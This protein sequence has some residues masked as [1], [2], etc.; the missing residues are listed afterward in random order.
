LR[1]R[2]TLVLVAAALLALPAVARASD[3]LV[4]EPEGTSPVTVS[5]TGLGEPDVQAREYTI[6]D[7][8]GERRVPVTGYS[9]DKVLDAANVDP[10]RFADLQVAAAAGL[11]V[12]LGRDEV[13][14][15]DTFAE[16]PPV[17]WMDAEEARFLRPQSAAA[18]SVLVSGG[19]ITVS[20]S[21]LSELEV[22]VTASKRRVKVGEPVTFTATVSGAPDGQEVQLDWYFD[23]ETEGSGSRIT[24]RFMR[25]G[26]YDVL[27]GATT[28]SDRTGA[29]ATASVRVGRPSGG[30]NRKG[31]G[32]NDDANAPDSG[33]ATGTDAS[34]TGGSGGAAA[35]AAG[36]ATEEAG[37]E[38][39]AAADRRRSARRRARRE[40]RA[41]RRER[42]REPE[43]ADA[44]SSREVSGIELADL[45]ALSSPAGRDALQAART[46]RLRDE[47]EEDDGRGVPPAVWWTLGTAA[48]LGLGG[49]REARG[50]PVTRAA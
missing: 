37:A 17:F 12:T 4:V 32:T 25:R 5:L 27:V 2:A 50:R 29:S 34:G 38:G 48:L 33:S 30:P 47:R 49:W 36:D 14:R 1:A 31:G 24:H 41:E 6:D 28:A 19:A 40:R 10:Y 43:P 20:L 39:D 26:T 9:L 18:G 35:A 23:D 21:R 42:Q 16:G 13:V 45:S 22:S 8:T 7:G 15:A 11:S 3:Q 46:G 44:G